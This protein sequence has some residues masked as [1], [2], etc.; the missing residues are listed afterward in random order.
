[1]L[2]GLLSQREENLR[3]AVS[4]DVHTMAPEYVLD[5]DAAP[6][7]QVQA[8]RWGEW[9]FGWNPQ[10]APRGLGLFSGHL[11]L[12]CKRP[13]VRQRTQVSL[14]HWMWIGSLVG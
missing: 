2:R 8:Q 14:Q 3:A 10:Q 4:A 11:G 1:M 12:C 6:R 7:L 9:C 5:P 13:P